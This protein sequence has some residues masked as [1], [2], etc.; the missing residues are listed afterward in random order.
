MFYLKYIFSIF[1]FIFLFSCGSAPEPVGNTDEAYSNKSISISYSSSN[2]LNI[3]DRQ[4]HV[5]P[6]IVYQLDNIN[7]FNS[8]KK[9]KDG[10]IK[11]LAA[12]KF[13]KSVMSVNKYYISPNE[14]KQLLLNRAEKTT[15]V[16]L[17]AG[18]YDMQPSKSTLIYQIPEYSSLKFWKS[19]FKQKFLLIKIFFDK[20]SI[21]Q[22]QE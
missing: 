12:K 8:L 14:I 10:I 9:D 15:W 7:G 13:D 2:K 11:L 18:Y 3:Y 1:I 21:K 22:R 17:V 5:I 16:A 6:L 20:F 4:S 19:E